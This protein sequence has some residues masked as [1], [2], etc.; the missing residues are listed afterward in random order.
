MRVQYRVLQ[1]NPHALFPRGGFSLQELWRSAQFVS[2]ECSICIPLEEGSFSLQTQS[3]N[4]AT[5]RVDRVEE[6]QAH[7]IGPSLGS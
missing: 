1:L 7:G 6:V 4:E 2:L 3:T 5:A